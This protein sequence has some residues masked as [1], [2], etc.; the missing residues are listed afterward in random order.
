MGGSPF[1][2]LY[3]LVFLSDKLGRISFPVNFFLILL[4]ICLTIGFTIFNKK[5]VA[6]AALVAINVI[7]VVETT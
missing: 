5:G 7:P 2:S 6:K 4:I 3:E 1:F